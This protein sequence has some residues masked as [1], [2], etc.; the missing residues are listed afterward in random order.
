MNL[1]LSSSLKKLGNWKTFILKLMFAFAIPSALFLSCA[2]ADSGFKNWVN[3]FK[4]TALA[5]GIS[6]STFDIA[7]KTVS[8][9]DPEVLE[10]AAYQPE[11]VD[12]AWNY[13]D[14]RIHDLAISEGRRQTEIWKKWLLK[15]EKRFGVDY[16]VLLAIWSIESNYGRV[17]SNKAV[18]RDAIRSL[19]TLAYADPKREKYARAQLIA[20]MKILQSGE[21][22]RS[23]L[24]G[25]WAG[26]LGHTQFIPTSYLTYA[27]DMDRNG[28]RDIWA[29]VPD[30]LA[31]AANLLHM[32]S[33]QSGLPWGFEVKLSHE[34]K[35]P[36]DW[37]SFKEWEKLGV[38]RA[39]GKPFPSLSELAKLKLPDGLGGPAFLVTKNFCVIK[40]YNNADRYAFAV[41]LLSD[42][43]AGRSKL[44]QDWNRPFKPVSFQERLELQSRLA[45]LGYYKG[46]IDGK[47]GT[48]SKK[49]IKAFQLRHGLKV[50][51]HPSH[52]ILLLL[53]KQ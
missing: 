8:T 22:H 28:R 23:Q 34:K 16:N 51:G 30:A 46:E 11:F 44:I 27:V 20:A 52:E 13:F 53:R 40:R 31:T 35:F 47:I 5:N 50:N 14:N 33:W 39:N 21:I 38:Q 49:A 42:R 2:Q 17:L 45:A 24:V 48:K 3:E 6:S 1:H 19:A 9:I 29:S 4:K 7:F 10:K 32:N 12:P 25:S 18:M 43:I 15:I 37:L 41:A 26:A 36:K